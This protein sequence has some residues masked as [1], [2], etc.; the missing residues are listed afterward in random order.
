MWMERPWANDPKCPAKNT[1]CLNCELILHYARQCKPKPKGKPREKIRFASEDH[2]AEE[3]DAADDYVF[4]IDQHDATTEIQ[5]GVSVA[6]VIDN[7][8]QHPVRNPLGRPESERSP[9]QDTHSTEDCLHMEQ[10]NL[11]RL[12]T[13][14]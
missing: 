12:S 4:T 11:F 6:V 8:Q 10:L 13:Y 5:I 2:R 7:A 1:V 14:S 3:E 9:L